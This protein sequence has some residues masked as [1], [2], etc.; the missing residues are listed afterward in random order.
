MTDVYPEL[1]S[2][3]HISAALLTPRQAV[4]KQQTMLATQTQD[5]AAIPAVYRD[6]ADEQLAADSARC[7]E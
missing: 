5:I 2:E 1:Q 6:G 7:V 3:R 4:K